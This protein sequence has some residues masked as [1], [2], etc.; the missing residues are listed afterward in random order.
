VSRWRQPRRPE[1]APGSALGAGTSLVAD[2]LGN[3]VAARS[4]APGVIF[5]S[6]P[7]QQTS[8]GV[9]LPS[10]ITPCMIGAGHL[11]RTQGTKAVGDSTL[12]LDTVLGGGSRRLD[13][14]IG[15]APQAQHGLRNER[16]QQRAY[17]ISK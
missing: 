4:P 10:T 5:R 9:T 8:V 2:A 13:R 3:A 12:G 1:V 11:P 16:R 7:G 15:P 17:S 6:D 14:I